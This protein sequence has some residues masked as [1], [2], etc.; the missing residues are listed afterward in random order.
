[1]EPG[2]GAQPMQQIDF[3]T[4]VQVALDSLLAERLALLAGA[5]LS[6]A[7]PSSLPSAAT[8][9]A[10]AKRKYDAIHGIGR[11]P[12]SPAI[13]HQAEFF[14]QRGALASVYFRTLI[15]P[16]IFPAPPNE[17]PFAVPAPLLVK[18]TKTANPTHVDVLMNT[19]GTNIHGQNK[20]QPA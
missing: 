15:D 6:M 8:I 14:F 4:G 3:D 10:E 18:G 16:H 13:E 9:A 12:L 19:T 7:P 20:T 5:G 2:A 17:G 11:A 1:M